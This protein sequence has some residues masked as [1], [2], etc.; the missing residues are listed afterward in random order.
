MVAGSLSKQ[1]ARMQ[2]GM[3]RILQKIDEADAWQG[4][5]LLRRKAYSFCDYSCAYM[6]G[7]AGNQGRALAALARSLLGYPL[8][9]Q[10]HEVSMPLARLKLLGMTLWRLLRRTGPVAQER[11]EPTLGPARV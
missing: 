8:P 5:G 9:F 10:R 2:A 7:A 11:N 4:E 3:R 6:H 1:A